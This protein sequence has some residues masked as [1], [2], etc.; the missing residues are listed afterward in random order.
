MPKEFDEWPDE[1]DEPDPEGRWGDPE[2]DLAAIPSVEVPGESVDDEGAGIEVDGDLA[3]FF[4]A[5]VIYANVA[6]AGISL[7]LLLVGFRG[8]WGWGGGALA[9][10]LFALYRTYDLYRTYQEREFGD[11]DPADA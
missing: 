1:P 3:K 5:T 8:Q 7:G 11:D 10:G 9:V 4:W 6:L 2:S